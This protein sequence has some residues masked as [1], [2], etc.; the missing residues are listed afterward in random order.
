MARKRTTPRHG[1]RI[2]VK[3]HPEQYNAL[4]SATNDISK[5]VRGLIITAL[6]LPQEPEEDQYELFGE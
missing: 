6:N 4:Y 5:F 3:L 1:V 2:V